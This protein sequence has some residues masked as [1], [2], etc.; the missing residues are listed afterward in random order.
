MLLFLVKLHSQDVINL[1][2]AFSNFI[3][4]LYIC[5]VVIIVHFYFIVHAEY[6]S[7]ID[8]YY[9]LYILVI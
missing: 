6:L 8:A 1:V 9:V 5:S 2:I 3:V 7:Y 4:R